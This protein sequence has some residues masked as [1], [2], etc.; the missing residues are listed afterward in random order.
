MKITC[1]KTSE[2][3]LTNKGD[4]QGLQLNGKWINPTSSG[5]PK[6]EQETDGQ[7]YKL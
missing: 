7:N 4:Q 6:F 2:T 5:E 1:V 3:K